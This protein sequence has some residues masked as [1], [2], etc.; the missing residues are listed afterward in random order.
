MSVSGTSECLS[1]A[2]VMNDS[3]SDVA[4]MTVSLRRHYP[5]KFKR[6]VTLRPVLASHPLSP[7]RPSSRMDQSIIY[8]EVSPAMKTSLLTPR[9]RTPQQFQLSEDCTLTR[10]ARVTWLALRSPRGGA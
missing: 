2:T 6:S 1:P 8:H 9:M 7:V 3:E 4:D 5:V 10:K